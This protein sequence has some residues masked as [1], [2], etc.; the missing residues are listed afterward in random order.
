M[1]DPEAPREPPKRMHIEFLAAAA[2]D[3]IV[4]RE[5]MEEHWRLL[6]GPDARLDDEL[7]DKAVALARIL[8]TPASKKIDMASKRGVAKAQASRDPALWHQATM[9]ALA[10]RG[11]KHGFLPWVLQQAET[12]RATAGWIFLWA[13]GSRYLRGETDFL[14]DHISSENMVALFDAV[15]ERSEGMGFANDALGLDPGFEAERLNCLAVIANGQLAPGIVAPK[16]LLERPFDPPRQDDRFRM[17]DGII[18]CA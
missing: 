7:F 6:R 17:D 12:D 5:R 9:A 1:T 11:D 15:C 16:A 13:E 2:Y 10:Y 18:L 4:T 14:L 8:N 3:G